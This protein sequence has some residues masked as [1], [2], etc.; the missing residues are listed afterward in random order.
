MDAAEMFQ[1]A[2]IEKGGVKLLKPTTIVGSPDCRTKPNYES[3]CF[4]A[5]FRAIIV[6]FR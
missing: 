3:G 6:F 4:D 5:S 1:L 2:I